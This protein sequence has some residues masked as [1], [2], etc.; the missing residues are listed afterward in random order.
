MKQRTYS[1]H[2]KKQQGFTLL[3]LLVVVSVLATL[4]GITAVAMDGYEQDSQE[5]LVQTEMKRIA[6][7]IY[8]F[9]ED[10][11][12][13][14]EE[15]IF[16]KTNASNAEKSGFEWLFFRPD[17]KYGNPVLWNINTGKGWNG[18]YL[19][20]ESSSNLA[21]A[22]DPN[23]NACSLTPAIFNTAIEDNTQEVV[24]A[25][26]DVFERKQLYSTTSSCFYQRNKKGKWVAKN[27]AGNAYQYDLEYSSPWH[28]HCTGTVKCIALLSL[29]DKGEKDTGSYLD[30]HVYV[31]RVNP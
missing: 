6:S 22:V 10:T 23:D 2:M 20:L 7:A 13:F 24:V 11:G 9:K 25:I 28:P 27:Y 15:G 5:Q 14:P 16:T 4:A 19:E 29:G 26:E 12:Y 31:L 21:S 18:P 1:Q 30:D 8:R 17:D 3:E